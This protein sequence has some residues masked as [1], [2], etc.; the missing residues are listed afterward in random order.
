MDSQLRKDIIKLLKQLN[1]P[2]CS[3]TSLT[4]ETITNIT[5][6]KSGSPIASY[7]NE[8]GT[9]QVFNETIT[10]MAIVGDSLNYTN[11]EG[12]V[13]SLDLSAFTQQARIVSGFYTQGT[14]VLTL[15]RDDSSTVLIDISQLGNSTVTSQAGHT[16]AT[17]TSSTGIVVNINET[18]TTLTVNGNIL[19]YVNE[20]G[21]TSTLEIEQGARIVSGTY[22]EITGLITL[23]RDDLTTVTVDLGEIVPVRSVITDTIIG[24]LIATHDDGT[25]LEVPINE[26]ITSLSLSGVNLTY[27]DEAGVATAL[28]LS[29]LT[30][31][32]N[33]A[34]IVSGSIDGNILT[35]VRDDDSII[36][37]DLG[38]V[39]P[40]IGSIS[41]VVTGNLIA[42]FDNGLGT[43]YPIYETV[44]NLTLI[45]NTLRY[46]NEAGTVTELDLAQ[47]V[48]DARIVS[49]ALVGTDLILT[50]DDST[51]VTIDM[52]AIFPEVATFTLTVPGHQIGLFDNGLVQVPVRETI[53]DMFLVGTEL[54]Y[55]REDGTLATVEL[56]D[57]FEDTNLPRIV[58]GSY[59]TGILTLTRDDASVINI[60]LPLGTLTD[61]VT[62]HLIGNLNTDVVTP[63]YET[64]TSLELVGSNLV[65]TNEAGGVVS[66][67]LDTVGSTQA[68]IVTAE[69]VAG[70]LILT[71]DDSTTVTAD[72]QLSEVTDTVTGHLIANHSSQGVTT[73]I[74][75]TITVLSLTG[76]ILT[77]VNEAGVEADLDLSDLTENVN[78]A[79]IVSGE[80]SGDTLILT[81]NDGSIITVTLNGFLP[82]TSLLTNLIAG[83][84]IATHN[85]GLGTEVDINETITSLTFLGTVLTYNSE[86]GSSTIDLASLNTNL[87][88][89]IEGEYANN[90]LTLT[91]DDASTILINL[92]NTQNVPSVFSNTVAG[93][94]IGTHV[95]GGITTDINE[96]VTNLTLG[97]TILTYFRED[98]TTSPIDLSGFGPRPRIVS[99]SV[100]GTTLT[101]LRDDS[102]SVPIDLSSLV[103]PSM[104][105]LLNTDANLKPIAQHTAGGITRTIS[106]TVTSL[107]YNTG[108]NIL[109]HRNEAGVVNSW[110]LA[111]LNRARIVSGAYASS[112]LTLT[113]DDGTNFSITIPPSTVTGT[114]PGH[115]IANHTNS[116]GLVTPIRET[117]TTLG[118]VGN[119]LTYINENGLANPITLPTTTDTFVTGGT[120]SSGTLLL[121]RNDGA[122]I[123]IA[124][125]PSTIS[126][127]VT[128]NPIATH[129][130]STGV[131][132]IIRETIT[133]LTRVGDELRYTN[134][135]G[136]LQ[137]IPLTVTDRF[138]SAGSY[139]GG[140]LVLTVTGAPTLTIPIP[141]S[142]VTNTQAGKR[143][144]THTSGSGTVTDI[145]ETITDIDLT[146]N[147]LSYERE[148]GE[149][150]EITLP[151]GA[152]SVLTPI[153][154]GN[155]IATHSNGS[156][157]TQSIQE[158]VTSITIL[159]GNIIRYT[160]ELGVNTN[161]IYNNNYV[162]GVSYS[163]ATQ[164]GTGLLTFTRVGL[165][166][167]T[168]NIPSLTPSAITNTVAGHTI[169]THT[170][171]IGV[172]TNIRESITTLGLTGN[173]LTYVNEAGTSIPLTLPVGATSSITGTIAGN[174][175]GTHNN[176]LGV[177]TV[178]RETITN[179]SLSGN[180]LTY[181]RESGPPNVINLPTGAT[182]S[183]TG[184]VSG[185]AI[186]THNN[187][188]GTNTV[189][190]ETVTSLTI[191]G[192]TLTYTDE[193]GTANPVTIPSGG[194]GGSGS[195]VYVENGI[196]FNQSYAS[197]IVWN[198]T[199]TFGNI[200][201]ITGPFT[202]GMTIEVFRMDDGGG[203]T[204]SGATIAG[205]SNP[206]FI[207]EETW[208]KG[209]FVNGVWYLQTL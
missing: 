149:I 48:G 86:S 82:T 18:V 12:T 144:A 38:D 203:I 83:N 205:G 197:T 176:G 122:S 124:L 20:S 2:L 193:N 140:N 181:I 195:S 208:V 163:Q 4:G 9:I 49:G 71:R 90:V 16:I 78:I 139:T 31:D 42:T 192:S 43:Q 209:A 189:I 127:L 165:P 36:T 41:D 75:E 51:T 129:V 134:E 11:E 91:R 135:A 154:T 157:I 67:P 68:R 188:A 33:L 151:T 73:P 173:V 74:N 141:Q 168:V 46:T 194:G 95:A 130:S 199:G 111:G 126:N 125:P 85:N 52:A 159:P 69:V 26:T 45:S 177:S 204:F 118:L 72:L 58:T 7:Q 70:E 207:A 88:R 14:G 98:G 128:G 84:R 54:R 175:I 92:P 17:H 96:T 161:L 106:E 138:L 187:G 87:P 198:G 59:A 27:T 23:V 120:Y 170:N 6:I 79:T 93:H 100:A 186:G 183:I 114:V 155:P 28:D 1:V 113:R 94:R 105:T 160:N 107:F 115:L 64:I 110:S 44:T 123:N 109:T 103:S 102:S 108:T 77:Y 47:Y 121:T 35:L 112:N 156:G 196:N 182:S 143:I 63:I 137:T 146:G 21:V 150:T 66:I 15:V 153:V 30:E 104:V 99:G 53:T 171:A 13:S 8:A 3:E 136:V 174:P 10:Y 162:N 145:R 117:V 178:I 201:T 29:A 148:D 191:S 167:L 169:A 32:I 5:P 24:H 180:T 34:V 158:T 101:L 40:A 166:N 119:V 202:N 65:F 116:N 56:S 19:T 190:R 80:I 39:I 142:V 81:R 97:G 25:G 206:F 172:M 131:S 133:N 200:M 152:T 184:T 60:V 164:F 50:R 147:I 37:I 62:G 179:L 55:N 57:L 132:S 185:H 61:T 22:N 76:T 89:I